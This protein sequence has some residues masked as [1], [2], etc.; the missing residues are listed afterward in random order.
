MRL[1]YSCNFLLLK[2]FTAILLLAFLLFNAVGYRLFI[3][4]MEK[5][6]TALLDARLDDYRFDTSELLVFKIPLQRLSYY[7]SS[8]RFERISGEITVAGVKYH[9]VE[10]RIMNDSIELHCVLNH[11]AMRWAAGN[12]DFFQ[13]VNGLAHGGGACSGNSPVPAKP[14][15]TGEYLAA[16]RVLH[17]PPPGPSL[18]RAVSFYLAPVSKMSS[19]SPD[20]PP[21]S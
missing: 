16:E 4:S 11:D 14:D 15:M 17:L 2:Q 21:Q 18:S 1:K 10:S 5:R 12:S 19:R 8:L 13:L 20:R 6:A 9:Y 3:T 7:H